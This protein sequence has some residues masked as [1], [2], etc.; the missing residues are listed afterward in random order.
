MHATFGTG[1]TRTDLGTAGGS[2]FFQQEQAFA[3]FG[4]VPQ[5]VLFD[6]TGT[7]VIERDPYGEG[8]HRWHNQMLALADT[9]GF[10]PKLCRPYRAKTKGKVERFHSSQALAYRAVMAGIKRPV[11]YRR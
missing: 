6:N 10:M 2:A 4:G 9:Y 11:H 5:H 1:N 7:V 8:R 3:Y